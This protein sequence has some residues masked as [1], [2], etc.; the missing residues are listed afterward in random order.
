MNTTEFWTMYREKYQKLEGSHFRLKD[1]P[2]TG[3]HG[4]FEM[5]FY[6]D[7]AGNWFVERTAERSNTPV[8][9]KFSS[10]QEAI[11]Y[12]LGQIK[13]YQTHI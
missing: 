13:L 12:L 10:E 4:F 5:S 7:G 8:Q 9:K 2:L 6:T 3:D 11:H 1:S